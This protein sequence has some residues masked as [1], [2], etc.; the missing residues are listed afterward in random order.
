MFGRRK[1]NTGS[2]NVDS[3]PPDIVSRMTDFGEYEFSPQTSR[4]DPSYIWSGIVAPLVPLAQQDPAGFLRDLAD[5]VLPAGGWAV[6]G[7]ARLVKEVLDGGSD[8]PSY[9]AMMSASLDFLRANGISMMHI[10]GYERSFWYAH[11]GRT[12]SW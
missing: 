10:N 5:A 7:G 3:L 8:D 6:F 1:S 12:E 2:S 11:K 4:Q 9:A